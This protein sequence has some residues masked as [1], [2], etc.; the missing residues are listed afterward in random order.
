MTARDKNAPYFEFFR[1]R[2]AFI[3]A[4]C[5]KADLIEGYIL[6]GAC[7]DSLA[8]IYA[9]CSA[10]GT[11][12]KNRE[13]FVNFLLTFA[14]NHH[15][16]TVSVPLLGHD[17]RRLAE[18]GNREAKA[19]LQETVFRQY[20]EAVTEFNKVWQCI[21]DMTWTARLTSLCVCCRRR[22]SA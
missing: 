10:S 6:W 15:L 14:P 11:K 5:T 3:R 7:V 16:D 1:R 21:E 20:E 12:Q 9:V 17:L 22:E 8:Q 4:H 19:A 13:R 2:I 18:S